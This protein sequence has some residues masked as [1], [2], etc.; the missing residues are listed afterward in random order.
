VAPPG[1]VRFR[2]ASP[3]DLPSCGA[4]WRAALNGYLRRLN[5]P[6]VADDLGPIGRLHGHTLATDPERFIVAVR[7]DAGRPGGDRPIA[8]ASA[9]ERGYL[10][11][12][13]MLFVEP[14]HQGVGLGHALLDRIRPARSAGLL[15]PVE[16]LASDSAQP[17]SNALYSSL[18]IVPRAPLYRLVGRPTRAGALPPLPGGVTA[19]PFDRA[20]DDR[21]SATGPSTAVEPS[22][23]PTQSALPEAVGELDQEILGFEHPQDHR[24]AGENGR[25]GFLYRA[26]D[27]TAIGYG[28]TSA[29]GYLGP[30]AV[31]E[32]SLLPA[33][34]GHL[35]SALEPRGASAAWVPGAA[36][37]VFSAL[38][39]AGLRIDGF[40]L[41]LCWSRPFADFS[42]YLPLSPGLL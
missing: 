34:I 39:R 19:V 35:L 28:Y 22:G 32:A 8:F 5:L 38:I 14:G 9:V 11:Y 25:L 4:I 2:P 26:A 40:P 16:A 27:G 15:G 18:G 3:D 6:D 29:V 1:P 31:R 20:D 30:V 17:I 33:V 21:R 24:Y 42:R 36:G 13:S 7:P 12:L 10:W 23:A 37:E 41:M